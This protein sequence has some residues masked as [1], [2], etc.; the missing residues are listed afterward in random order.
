M[1]IPIKIDMRQ[2]IIHMK[3]RIN[4]ELYYNEECRIKLRG[5]EMFN[6]NIILTALYNDY[7]KHKD[8]FSK[9]QGIKQEDLANNIVGSNANT[10]KSKINRCKITLFTLMP[11]FVYCHSYGYGHK[12]CRKYKLNYYGIQLVEAIMN[13]TGIDNIN[14]DKNKKEEV[15]IEDDDEVTEDV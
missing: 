6:I 12:D 1:S 7:L 4:K 2:A 10:D 8:D 11:L 3:R 5:S 9:Y 14:L 15:E 13:N